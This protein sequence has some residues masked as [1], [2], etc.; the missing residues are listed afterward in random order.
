MLAPEHLNQGATDG[1]QPVPGDDDA[2]GD[3]VDL[4][5][6]KLRYRVVLERVEV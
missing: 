1:L 6:R 2:V 3:V 5:G 4:L